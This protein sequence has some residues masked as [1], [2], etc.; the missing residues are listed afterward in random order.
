MDL[1]DR[2]ESAYCEAAAEAEALCF[3]RRVF[4]RVVPM[5]FFR[6]RHVFRPSEWA[7]RVRIVRYRLG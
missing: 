1:G 4:H 2:L 7:L 5:R 6:T 3:E